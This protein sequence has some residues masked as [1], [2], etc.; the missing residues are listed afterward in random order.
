MQPRWGGGERLEARVCGSKPAG[1]V[2]APAED[3]AIEAGASATA[4][5]AIRRLARLID[6][7]YQFLPNALISAPPPVRVHTREHEGR[8][9]PIV[10]SRRWP[11]RAIARP[12][13]ARCARTRRGRAGRH[14]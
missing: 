14:G 8:R 1:S 12:P 4:I 10:A 6:G 2:A 3:D 5:M 7:N 13:T 11:T 9:Y